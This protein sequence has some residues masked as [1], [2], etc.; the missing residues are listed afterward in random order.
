MAG[1][2]V[3]SRLE[4]QPKVAE[5]QNGRGT[6]AEDGPRRRQ[7]LEL[8]PWLHLQINGKSK[9]DLGMEP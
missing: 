7:A 4:A 1:A 2:E 8:G 9:H 3:H 6:G 5:A